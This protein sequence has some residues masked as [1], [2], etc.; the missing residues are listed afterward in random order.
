MSVLRE[1]RIGTVTVDIIQADITSMH[2]DV[3]V[4][5]ANP[6]SFMPMDGGV[7]GALRNM[8]RPVD[9]TRQPKVW[10]D[11]AGVEHRDVRLPC[12]Q[13]GVQ[14]AAGG[15]RDRGV[16]FVVHAVGPNWNDFPI[17]DATFARVLPLIRR[18][19]SR[20]LAAAERIGAR[21]CAI[22]AISGGIFTHWREHSDIKQQEQRA[23]RRAVVEAVV[24][25]AAGQSDA[26]ALRVVRLCDRDPVTVRY[27][28]EAMDAVGLQRDE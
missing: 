16:L 18:T 23:A 26:S 13:A 20:A 8:C 24:A 21:S 4:N 10:W 17:A 7:S 6:E 28:A 14:A 19:V 2:M 25:W 9:V 1:V 11:D 12:T 5:A 15:L 27:F 3:V 22:P